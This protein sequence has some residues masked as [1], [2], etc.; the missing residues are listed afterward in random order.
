MGFEQRMKQ[1]YSIIARSVVVFCAVLIN[2]F[3]SAD[4][5]KEKLFNGAYLAHASAEK[6]QAEFYAPNNFALG[7]AALTAAEKAYAKD[8]PIER[9]RA[10]L[11]RAIGLYEKAEL[12][13]RTAKAELATA[14]S[15]REA[16]IAMNAKKFRPKEWDRA[17]QL[18]AKAI[19]SLEQD[20]RNRAKSHEEKAIIIYRDVELVAIK[21]EYLTETRRLIAEAKA[22]RIE[23]FAPIT[24]RKAQELLAT[25]EVELT[26][27][28]YDV[29]LPRSLAKEAR[30][31]VNHAF[32]IA[33]RVKKNRDQNLSEEKILLNS[34]GPL[35]KVAAAADV[36]AR[37][38]KGLDPVAQQMVEYIETLNAEIQEY[39]QQLADKDIQIA[40]LKESLDEFAQLYGGVGSTAE[41][42]EKYLVQHDE[43]LQRVEQ[44]EAMFDRTEARVFRDANEIYIRLIGLSFSS[45]SA[46]IG[47][48]NYQLL[49]KVIEVLKLYPGSRVIVE[50]HTDAF[51]SDNSNLILSKERADAVRFFLINSANLDES[52]IEA[53]GFGE[54]RPF[55]NNDTPQGRALN[56]RIDVKILPKEP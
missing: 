27:N 35:Q 41:D 26:E 53:L 16:A 42:L 52:K 4:S 56:R 19:D 7:L 8:K 3:A 36:N 20:K 10:E 23:R 31:E 55:A 30:Y 5:A 29:D 24:V 32:Y 43:F 33:E 1:S 50:G 39:K 28:R 45:G 38:D 37:F 22:A 47:V 2:A 14:L 34:E 48:G 25:A 9:V 51:G 13:T 49:D 17:E 12:A 54:T 46:R 11:V 6:K 44:I 18:L 15:A 21:A 40:G